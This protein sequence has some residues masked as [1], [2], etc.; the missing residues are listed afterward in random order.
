MCAESQAHSLK[1]RLC[2][3]K[4]CPITHWTLGG[5]KGA[6]GRVARAIFIYSLQRVD[7]TTFL[8]VQGRHV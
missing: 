6:A 1:R 4:A 3:C 8:Q 5:C 2:V 7:G